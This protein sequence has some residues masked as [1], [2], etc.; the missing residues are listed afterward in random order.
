MNLTVAFLNWSKDRSIERAR[1]VAEFHASRFKELG[2]VLQDLRDATKIH[3]DRS[4]IIALISGGREDNG[5][6]GRYLIIL[7]ETF[8][9]SKKFLDDN[10]HLL[11]SPRLASLEANLADINRMSEFEPEAAYSMAEKNRDVVLQ[12]KILPTFPKK[13]DF[14]ERLEVEV[15]AELREIGDMLSAAR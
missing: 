6:V 15:Q 5:Q 2:R 12:E 14:I 9:A 10:R 1:R 8:L 11:S 4:E 13:L 3:Y 7:Q